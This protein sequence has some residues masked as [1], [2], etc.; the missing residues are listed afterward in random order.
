MT[1]SKIALSALALSAA[2][3]AGPTFAQNKPGTE[4]A[5][6]IGILSCDLTQ[7]DNDI[8]RSKSEYLCT[9]D[10]HD[11]AFDAK[12]VATVTKWG[13]DLSTTDQET[14]KWA[15]LTTQEKYAKD[16]MQG[17]YV[18]AGADIA[19]KY[20]AGVKVLVGGDADAISLQPLSVAGKE[21]FGVAVGLDAMDIAPAPAM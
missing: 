19:V 9:M 8:L 10:A 15:V 4:G 3:V 1:T 21:G 5:A 16:M 7:K 2:L 20:G 17:H 11:D 18:G 13:V 14:I 12:Y 6:E